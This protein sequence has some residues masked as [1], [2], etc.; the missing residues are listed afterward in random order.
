MKKNKTA[1]IVVDMLYDFIDGSMACQNSH[2]AIN[3]SIAFINSNPEQTVFYITDSHPASHCSFKENGGIW[4]TH[5][6]TGTN[7]QKISQKYYTSIKEITQ[8][9]RQDNI[10][11]KGEDPAV[12]QYSGF[13]AISS[14]GQ[15][16]E[17]ILKENNT[18][19]V[20]VSGIATEYCIKA[21]VTDLKNAGFKVNLIKE[22]LAY[23]EYDGHIKTLGDLKKDG[24]IMV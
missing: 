4:P 18:S 5:C 17:S 9:P 2:N 10:L 16:L 1:H 20:Y 24:I 22:A 8:R 21:T 15:T 19:E 13:E 23:V 12:E 14:T 7:G 11:K 6:V 3:K